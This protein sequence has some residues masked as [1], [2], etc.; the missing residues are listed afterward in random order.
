MTKYLFALL[1][2][3]Q[4]FAQVE[5]N[6]EANPAE[7]LIFVDRQLRGSGTLKL[8]DLGPGQHLLRVSAG[9]DWETH[10]QTFQ[11]QNRPL[12]LKVAL[13]PG[14]AKWMRLG[15]QALSYGDWAE[16]VK[17]FRMASAARPVA[18]SWWEGVSHWRA[19]QF[20][21]A[22]SAFRKYAQ[23]MPQ[24]PQLHWIL[25]QLHEQLHRPGPAFTAY[26]QVALSLPE[27]SR[28]LD[29]LP[30]VSDQALAALAGK[31]S[32]QDRLR[33]AQ[34][35]MLKGKHS[36]ACELVKQILGERFQEDW[37]RWEP[38]LP[39]PA[40]IEVAPPEDQGY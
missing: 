16:A 36:Q 31:S 4:A 3:A 9:E 14:S 22:I 2:S 6:V 19:G 37:L 35:L 34:L 24:V 21:G 18:A 12:S 27:L 26:K 25:G 33:R 39:A 8:T 1:L 40:P 7:A 20:E 17:S 23:F 29:K 11:L 32:P 10:T 28:A 13:K 15:R 5:V 30:P 38:P